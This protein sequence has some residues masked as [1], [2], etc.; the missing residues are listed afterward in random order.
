MEINKELAII[1]LVWCNINKCREWAH[2]GKCLIT[3]RELP[4][5]RPFSVM[6][7]MLP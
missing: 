1:S 7:S 2:V 5:S 6:Y 3:Q 4:V